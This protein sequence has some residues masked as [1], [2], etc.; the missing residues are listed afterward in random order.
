MQNVYIKW[1]PKNSYALSEDRPQLEPVIC[2]IVRI[3]RVE[4]FTQDSPFIDALSSAMR[5]V[6]CRKASTVSSL[7]SVDSTDRDD[8]FAWGWLPPC[9][10]VSFPHMHHNLIPS[11]SMT[12]ASKPFN[13]IGKDCFNIPIW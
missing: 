9:D 2:D 12:A 7:Q 6:K 11:Y 1:L 4:S 5:E 3:L 13:D 8:G 10:A